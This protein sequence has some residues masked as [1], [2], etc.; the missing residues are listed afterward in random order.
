MSRIT[1]ILQCRYPGGGG[2]GAFGRP[3]PCRCD[4]QALAWSDGC[5]RA[6]QAAESGTT[7]CAVCAAPV[8]VGDG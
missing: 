4:V 6:L 1:G 7:V 5:A 8:V 3:F 2:G